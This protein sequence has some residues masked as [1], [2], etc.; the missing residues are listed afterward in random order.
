MKLDTEIQMRIRYDFCSKLTKDILT[1][2][3]TLKTDQTKQKNQV[4]IDDYYSLVNR[5]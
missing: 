2:L 4:C 3:N 5:H 1:E